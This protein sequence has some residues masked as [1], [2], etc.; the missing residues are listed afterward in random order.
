M[1]KQAIDLPGVGNARELGGY[2]IGDRKVRGGVL[3]RTASLS[4]IEPEAIQRLRDEYRLQT[5]VDF[6]MA[7]EQS[8]VPDPEI[9]GATNLQLSVVELADYPIPEGADPALMAKT[10][11]IL[12]DPRADRMELFEISYQLGMVGPDSYEAFLLGERGKA[13]YAAFFR[14]ILELEDGRAILWHCTD[15]KD[16]AGCASA[17]VLS[18]LGASRGLLLEDYLLTNE[19]NAVVVEGVRQKAAAYQMPPEKRDALVFMTG[20]VVASYLTHVLDLLVERYGSVEAY[21]AEELG[22][23]AAEREELRARFLV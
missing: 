14:T 18:A 13:A 7:G 3:L 10:T 16:R 9:P 12:K 20:G 23:G 21:L 2:A 6:R 11:A 4:K 19:F 5:V 17:L 22:V 1:L 8:H 15:G